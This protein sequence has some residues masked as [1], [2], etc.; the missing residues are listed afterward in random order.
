MEEVSCDAVT[1]SISNL[2]DQVSLRS[3]HLRDGLDLEDLTSQSDQ[4][5]RQF[6]HQCIDLHGLY[7]MHCQHISHRT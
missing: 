3:K 1:D 2:R 5:I 6:L 7:R 4:E